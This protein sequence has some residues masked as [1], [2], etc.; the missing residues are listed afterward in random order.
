LDDCD[1]AEEILKRLE[2]QQSAPISRGSFLSLPG[3]MLK[4][5]VEGRAAVHRF[6]NNLKNAVIML[7]DLSGSEWSDQQIRS[8]QTMLARGHFASGISE[9]VYRL[10]QMISGLQTPNA[11]AAELGLACDAG[12]GISRQ[13]TSVGEGAAHT[14]E[15]VDVNDW[16]RKNASIVGKLLGNQATLCLDL[17]AESAV[18]RLPTRSLGQVMMNTFGSMRRR[19]AG[20][21]SIHLKT[22]VVIGLRENVRLAFRLE[23][24][25]PEAWTPFVF[26]F[27]SETSDLEASVANAIVTAAE[28]RLDYAQSWANAAQI[29]ILLPRPQALVESRDESDARKA[30]GVV[31]LVGT[32]KVATTTLEKQFER[33]GYRVIRSASAP[34]ALIVAQFHEGD[35]NAVVAD[36]DTVSPQS[37][38]RVERAF[39]DRNPNT[40]FIWRMFGFETIDILND[41]G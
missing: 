40:K 5:P 28:G 30:A 22:E 11:A 19:L 4:I 21:G 25:G 6:G 35:I 17:C 33:G 20:P 39:L 37:R 12:M 18:V 7:R 16:I 1:F 24:S 9:T 41:L 15:L 3:G 2:R 34:E 14:S 26:P 38:D 10:F 27:E 32:G 23:R 29:E 13:L 31:L 36:V 8:E